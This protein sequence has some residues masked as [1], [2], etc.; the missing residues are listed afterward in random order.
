MW[1]ALNRSEADTLLYDNLNVPYER[2]RLDAERHAREWCVAV[3]E[4]PARHRDEH[5]ARRVADEQLCA[6]RQRASV[7]VAQRAVGLELVR[8]DVLV[9]GGAA[10]RG[11]HCQLA[12]LPDAMA[13]T[14]EFSSAV[15]HGRNPG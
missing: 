7:T 15:R 10:E 13:V 8:R 5:G 9:L 3:A 11:G 4:P 1:G 2:E 12:Q 14:N 6:P